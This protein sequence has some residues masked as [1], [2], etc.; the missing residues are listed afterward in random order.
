M[1]KMHLANACHIAGEKLSGPFHMGDLGILQ[2]CMALG[3]DSRSEGNKDLGTKHQF[4]ST[5]VPK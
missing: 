2:H 3:S 4:L 1:V 5:Y